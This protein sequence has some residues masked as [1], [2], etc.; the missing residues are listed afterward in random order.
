MQ[1]TPMAERPSASR[2][3]SARREGAPKK[4]VRLHRGRGNAGGFPRTPVLCIRA[5]DIADDSADSS[6]KG[7]LTALA[8]G[9]S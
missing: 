9:A 4:I 1:R 8:D 2:F 7:A 6:I 5:G 3:R